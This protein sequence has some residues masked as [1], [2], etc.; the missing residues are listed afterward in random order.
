MCF[1]VIGRTLNMK[2][3]SEIHYACDM[4]NNVV[5]E[6]ITLLARVCS[7]L[8]QSSQGWAETKKKLAPS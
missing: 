2:N 6:L 8:L 5:L 3:T 7:L 1:E 4:Q